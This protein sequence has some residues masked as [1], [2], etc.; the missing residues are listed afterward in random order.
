MSTSRDLGLLEEEILAGIKRGFIEVTI[1]AD[2]VARY[3]IT[4]LGI[5][6]LDRVINDEKEE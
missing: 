6:H 4:E 3:R 2:G 1:D 5:K